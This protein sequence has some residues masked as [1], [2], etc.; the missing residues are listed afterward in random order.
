MPTPTTVV[1]FADNTFEANVEAKAAAQ[2]QL[3]TAQTAVSDAGT[4]SDDRVK[5]SGATYPERLF[6]AVRG[7][8]W[9]GDIG[10]NK[11]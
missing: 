3:S 1:E 11:H 6:G 10:G 4:L 2:A 9:K 5:R 8:D 7:D